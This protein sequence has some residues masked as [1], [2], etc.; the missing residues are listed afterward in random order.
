M[1]QKFKGWLVIVLLLF[2]TLGCHEEITEIEVAT[3]EIIAPEPPYPFEWE[4][5]EFMPTPS[6]IV[7]RVPWSNSVNI[8]YDPIIRYDFKSIDGWKLLYNTFNP[9]YFASGHFFA[10]YNKYRGIL[11][12]YIYLSLIHI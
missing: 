2:F 10:L 1:K 12:Y 8:L 5:A 9:N 7:V 3:N 4:T 11:R 6:N